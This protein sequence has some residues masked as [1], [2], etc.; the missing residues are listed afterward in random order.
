MTK[1]FGGHLQ[2]LLPPSTCFNST[3]CPI[4]LVTLSV[5]SSNLIMYALNERLQKVAIRPISTFDVVT[6]GLDSHFAGIVSKGR[7]YVNYSV[8]HSKI[9][10]LNSSKEHAETE[11]LPI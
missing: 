10:A 9:V 4:N 3:T 6:I 11:T 2:Q 5:A 7:S 8:T 1:C